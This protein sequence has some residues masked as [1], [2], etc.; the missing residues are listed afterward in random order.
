MLV[1]LFVTMFKYILTLFHRARLFTTT[2]K[3][4]VNFPKQDMSISGAQSD[5]E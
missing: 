4:F 3:H 2:K 1:V 5:N